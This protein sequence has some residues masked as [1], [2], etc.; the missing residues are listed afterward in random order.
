[1]KNDLTCGVVRD[2]LPSYVEGLLCGESQRAVDRHLAGCPHCAGALA[3]MRE[4]EAEAEEQSREVDY[5]KQVKKR[6]H[7]KIVLSAV[8]TAAVLIAGL[9]LGVFV[10]GT[11]LRPQNVAAAGR[12][13]N[14]VLHLSVMSMGSA[15]AFHGWRVEREDGV[16]SVYA[17]D[18]L[19]SFLFSDGSGSLDIPLEGLR[20]VWLGGPSGRLVWQDG[21]A[22]SRLALDLLEARSPY[23]GDS[24]G[25][26]HIA[27]L[28]RLEYD[29]VS[30]QTAER[31]YT[32]TLGFSG[33][34]GDK[35]YRLACLY[36]IVALALTDNL[37]GVLFTSPG[38]TDGAEAVSGIYLE[39]ANRLAAQLTQEYNN[40]HGTDW[41]PKASVKE[42]VQSPADLQRLL[43]L[44]EDFYHIDL[45]I[46]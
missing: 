14:N 6:G 43:L 27:E 5:L 35:E 41:E 2:L 7:G 21:V 17:R 3:A 1:M 25:P 36:N 26:A 4:P 42:Y 29:T 40:A 8:C 20:E 31:P 10:I 24:A 23:C 16:A 30:L 12:V 15:N 9:L 37:E 39:E 32:W 22:V 38:L 19:V 46:R 45:N 33:R 44:L 18:V 28:L 11:P 34:L 13:E